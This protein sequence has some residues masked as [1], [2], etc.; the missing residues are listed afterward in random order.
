VQW[1]DSKSH[2]QPIFHFLLA[3]MLGGGGGGIGGSVRDRDRTI[4]SASNESSLPLLAEIAFGLPYTL[5][6]NNLKKSS[7]IVVK[8]TPCLFLSLSQSCRVSKDIQI[9]S[10]SQSLFEIS[11]EL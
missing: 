4:I 5:S 6:K 1:P 2:F 8:A 9:T 3:F 7:G 11:P 10:F